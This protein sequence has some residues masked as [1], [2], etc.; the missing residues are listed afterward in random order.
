MSKRKVIGIP[1]WDVK[2][3]EFFGVTLPYL[4]WLSHLGD[5]SILTPG[6]LPELDLLVLPGGADVDTDRYDQLP[7]YYTSKPNHFL[8]SF[9]KHSLPVYVERKTPVFGICRGL[10]TIN[11]HFGGSLFQDI[12]HPSSDDASDIE[13]HGVFELRA[14]G[15]KAGKEIFKVGS[16]HHQ[17]IDRVAKELKVDLVAKDNIIEA[18]SHKTLPICAVQWHPERC[19]DE[20]SFNTVTKL[21][22]K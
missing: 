5:T 1:G 21:L 13:A 4:A 11:V 3:G 14:D 10:Q 16:W 8:E 2:P 15:T 18:V 12:V 9:D 17:S 20:Y 22:I 6:N 19:Y 7:S